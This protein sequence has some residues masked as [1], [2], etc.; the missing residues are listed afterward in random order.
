MPVTRSPSTVT[1][2]AAVAAVPGA[3]VVEDVPEPVPLGGALQRHGDD[4]VGAADAV[5]ELAVERLVGPV[6]SIVCTGLVRLRQPVLRAG[7][8]ER[9]RQRE[10]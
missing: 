3:A 4:V 10:G 5:R 9:L 1:T 6:S 2:S 8:V 7:L